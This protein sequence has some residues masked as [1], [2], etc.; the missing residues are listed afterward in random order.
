MEALATALAGLLFFHR[1]SNNTST[2]RSITGRPGYTGH[3]SS[4]HAISQNIHS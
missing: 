4:F 2:G 1:H 3:F